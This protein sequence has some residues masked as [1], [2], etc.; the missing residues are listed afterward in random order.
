MRPVIQGIGLEPVIDR[1][2]LE[3]AADAMNQ[4][5]QRPTF[6]APVFA[7]QEYGCMCIAVPELPIVTTRRRHVFIKHR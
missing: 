4:R 7:S 6:L 3:P 2:G 5:G 1:I